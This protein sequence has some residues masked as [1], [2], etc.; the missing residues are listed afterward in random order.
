MNIILFH[1]S[2]LLQDNRIEISDERLQHLNQ[3]LKKKA[4]DLIKIGQVNGQIGSGRIV[5]ISSQSATIE[6]APKYPP[7]E[8][9]PC[10]VVLAL[11]R[12]KMLS[13]VLQSISSMGVKD[14]HLINSWKVEKSFWESEKLCEQNIRDC[15]I[16]GLSQSVDTIL[17]RVVM[18]RL[19]RPFVEDVLSS[20]CKD[21]VGLVAHPYQSERCP[22]DIQQDTLL[23]IGPEA[24]F[25]D[26]EIGKFQHA[27][28]ASVS[29]GPR[30]LRVETAVPA[31]L[32]RLY[33]A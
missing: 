33:P 19:F 6:W 27:G 7:P 3:T 24:G 11:P 13:R 32:S 10:T 31:L 22:V 20:L 12:P 23:A 18:H 8:A 26:Y 14:I 17:P 15:L 1:E 4:G 30:I 28:L 16:A 9:V 5:N 2:E 29:L 21:R 25:T